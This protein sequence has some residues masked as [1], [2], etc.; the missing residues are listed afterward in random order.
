M[1][2]ANRYAPLVPDPTNMHEHKD[3]NPLDL[4]D[5]MEAHMLDPAGYSHETTCWV[6]ESD[7]TL[8]AQGSPATNQFAKEDA[9]CVLAMYD[10]VS[11]TFGLDANMTEVVLEDVRAQGRRIRHRRRARAP[12]RRD[13]CDALPT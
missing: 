1:L 8:F 2:T 12:S 7:G 5:G 10:R 13:S 3:G 11:S 4:D 6:A 9:Y